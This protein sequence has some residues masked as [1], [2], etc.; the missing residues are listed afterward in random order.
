M[1]ARG[2]GCARRRGWG[3][4]R[5]WWGGWG[6]L[7]WGGRGWARQRRGGE[8]EGGEKMMSG[9]ERYRGVVRG[10]AVDCLPRLP[11]LMAF[12]ARFIGSNY[13]AFASDHRGLVEGNKRCI[14]AF[15]FDPLSVISDPYRETHG[16]G[17]EIE[18]PED[19]VPKCVAPPLAG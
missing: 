18:Y 19:A 6:W 16:F 1:S 9:Y 5:S 14:E 15:G 7:G 10:E 8:G 17:A 3:R 2:W 12:A 13:R 11:I 4:R